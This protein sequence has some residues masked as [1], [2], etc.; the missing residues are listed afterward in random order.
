MILKEKSLPEEEGEANVSTDRTS[1][2]KKFCMTGADR[3]TLL[4][5]SV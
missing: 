4:N 2:K 1:E 5:T 3:R